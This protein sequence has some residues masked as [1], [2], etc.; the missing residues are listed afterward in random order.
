MI[1]SSDAIWRNPAMRITGRVRR[2]G[3]YPVTYQYP[4]APNAFGGY[5][6]DK[7]FNKL[8]TREKLVADIE[9]YTARKWTVENIPTELKESA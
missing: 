9:T 2:D 6:P 7:Y 8:V 4:G 1:K 5:Y 3:K